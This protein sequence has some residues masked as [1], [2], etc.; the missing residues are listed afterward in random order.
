MSVVHRVRRPSPATARAVLRMAGF[1]QR[2]GA[3]VEFIEYPCSH[4][5]MILDL[6]AGWEVADGRDPATPGERLGSF[7][8][9]LTTGPVRVVHGGWARCLQVDLAP[10]AARRLLGV[11]LRELA[12]RSVALRDVMGPSAEA[13]TGR[14]AEAATWDERFALVER[15]LARRLG[16]APPLRREVGWALGRIRAS[17]GAQPIGGLASELGW[18]ARRL[19]RGFRDEVGLPP[20]AVARIVRFERLAALAGADGPVDWARAAVAC[21]YF[22][23]AHMAREVRDLAGVTPARLRA[24]RINSVQSAEPAAA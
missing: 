2:A 3:P 8:A 17:G 20:K 14:L 4:V 1:E 11:P 7:A 18:S 6:G 19:I 9:G 21:G 10:R 13:L 23:Q 24:E 5:P 22:D 16:D 12:G 15:A